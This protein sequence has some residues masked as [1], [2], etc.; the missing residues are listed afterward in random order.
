MTLY[1]VGKNSPI[2]SALLEAV[3]NGKEV[4]VLLELQARF[5]EES[6]IEWAQALEAEGVH[7]IYGLPGL[8]VHCKVALVLRREP[9]GIRRYVHLGTGNYNPS[10]ARLYTDISLLTAN[11][12]IGRDATDLFNYLTGYS[13]KRTFRKLLIAPV[14]MRSRLEDMIRREI[15]RHS[16]ASPGHIIFKMNSLEDHAMIELL[17]AASQAGVQ[18]DLI[19]R[20]ICC[21][22]PG[23]PGISANIRVRSILGRFLE[24]SRIFYFRNG[25]QEEI[26]CGSADMMPRNLNRR[27]ETIFPVENPA[28]V[29]RLKYEILDAYLADT[30]RARLMDQDGNYHRL[31]ATTEIEPVDSQ[32]WFIRRQQ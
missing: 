11:E 5:D 16:V 31:R 2:V 24:H 8:K 19:V 23:M 1:R 30:A 4:A 27:V 13:A 18:V 9:G 20:G 17:Y 7:V 3:K 15:S 6:N 21:L 26:Y 12:D 10:T 29:R 32:A 25:G 14:N 28:H 22:R